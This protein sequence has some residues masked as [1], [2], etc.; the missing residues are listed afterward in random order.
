[1]SGEIIIDA[2]APARRR[3]PRYAVSGRITCDL[4]PAHIRVILLN[5]SRGGC[6]IRSPL[7][8]R[9]GDGHRF[10]FTLE[11]DRDALF[12]VRARVV[13]CVAVPAN[14]DAPYLVGLEFL[15]TTTTV[16]ERA[17]DRLVAAVAR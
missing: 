11:A 2:A 16:A 14:D 10:R 15:D 17:L 12:I 6:L 5:M 3:H 1:M 9:L 13:H 8:F 4:L 7:G